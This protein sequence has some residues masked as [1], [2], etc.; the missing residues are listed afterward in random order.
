MSELSFIMS[1]RNKLLINM[2]SIS[3]LC[4]QDTM[5]YGDDLSTRQIQWKVSIQQPYIKTLFEWIHDNVDSQKI[6]FCKTLRE[7]FLK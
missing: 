2:H 3:R 1:N 6:F 4:H 7:I 5:W